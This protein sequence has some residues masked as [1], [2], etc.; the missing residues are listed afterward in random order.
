LR[1][2]DA[3]AH[4]IQDEEDHEKSE[5]FWREF[6][7]LRPDKAALQKITLLH[8]EVQTRQLFSRAVACV[9]AGSAPADAHALDVGPG[10][11][12][13]S[14][15]EAD[16]VDHH[17]F[18]RLCPL[19]EVYESE[20]RYNKCPRGIRSSRCDL[21]GFRCCARCD[22]KDGENLYVASC[23]YDSC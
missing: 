17:S 11:V 10:P 22:D 21:H 23:C 15:D 1:A 6:F 4:H 19:Q 9:K 16:K 12:L 8:L 14:W 5:G 3:V 20:F 18:S 13:T 7:L 2:Q